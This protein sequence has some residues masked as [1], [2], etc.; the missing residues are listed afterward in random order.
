ME[1]MPQDSH[2]TQQD[3][4]YA[5]ALERYADAAPQSLMVPGHGCAP[6]GGGAHLAR[7]FGDRAVQLDVPLM[8]DGIDLGPGSPLEQALAL[9]AEAWGARRT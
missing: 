3:A 4:P 7:V 8:L 9:A 5:A 6:E 1:T 2:A